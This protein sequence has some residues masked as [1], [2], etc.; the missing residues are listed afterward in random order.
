[1]AGCQHHL[2]M[3]EL[4]I[5]S[6]YDQ[7]GSLRAVSDTNGNI[8]KEVTYDTYGNILTDTNSTFK[9]PY[10]FAGGIYD[11]DTK[12]TRFGYRDYVRSV[13]NRKLLYDFS[14]G[15]ESDVLKAPLKDTGK[16]T[17]KDPIDFG[18]GD[19]NLYGYVLGDPVNWVDSDGLN[20]YNDPRLNGRGVPAAMGG[21]GRGYSPNPTIIGPFGSVCGSGPNA[22]WVPDLF[23]KSC[24]QHDDCYATCGKSK[25]ECDNNLA[26]PYGWALKYPFSKQSQKAYN[27]AQ[28]GL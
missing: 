27:D 12:L 7:V 19:T 25:L 6:N 15:T 17:A 23:P 2:L 22:T 24:Q 26:W 1:M 4:S 10:G 16:W 13:K 28:K 21:D 14:F 3:E 5:I 9:V 11:T 20:P 8:V 18:G